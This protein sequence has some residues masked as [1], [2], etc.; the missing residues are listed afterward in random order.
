[1]RV[2]IDPQAFLVQRVGGVSRLFAEL[3][4]EL[5]RSDDVD[6]VLPLG[7]T[8]TEYLHR[9]FPDRMRLVEG[10]SRF[11]RGRALGAVNAVTRLPPKPVDIVHSTYYWPQYKNAY[12]ARKRITTVFDMIPEL[13]P[14]LHEPGPNPAS[15]Q[16]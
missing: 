13:M 12:R 14:E 5:D 10:D 16:A 9:Y 7:L 15:Q 11:L 8:R 4:R 6:L 1:M 2:L 3:A